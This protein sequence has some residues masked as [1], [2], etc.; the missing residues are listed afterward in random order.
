MEQEEGDIVV[1]GW[2]CHLR[3]SPWNDLSNDFPSVFTDYEQLYVRNR[4]SVNPIFEENDTMPSGVTIPSMM[5]NLPTIEKICDLLCASLDMDK[6]DIAATGNTGLYAT[7]W[8]GLD[9]S[10]LNEE[11][12]VNVIDTFLGSAYEDSRGDDALVKKFKWWTN[13][14]KECKLKRNPQSLEHATLNW[15]MTGGVDT[16]STS[17]VKTENL[18][19]GELLTRYISA[20]LLFGLV[21]SRYLWNRA[22][23]HKMVDKWITSS[24]WT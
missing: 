14:A 12:I 17:S 15:L 10:T 2:D 22:E 13:D 20:P 3:E 9:T 21:S 19:E 18:I 7:H 6:D 8:G 4:Q 1:Q 24:W 16:T 23:Q 11:C 5:N